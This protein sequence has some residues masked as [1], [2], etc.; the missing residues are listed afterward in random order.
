MTIQIESSDAVATRREDYMVSNKRLAFKFNKLESSKK[1]KTQAFCVAPWLHAHV[2][3]EGDRRLCCISDKAPEAYAKLPWQ[4]FKNS[5]YMK[6][7]RTQMLSNQVPT[8]CSACETPNRKHVYRDHLNNEYGSEIPE[9]LENTEADG[10]TSQK[11]RFLDYRSN[12]C[13]LKCRTC[14]PST[15]SANHSFLLKNFN[16]EKRWLFGDLERSTPK[17]IMEY[18]K[19]VYAVEALELASTESIDQIYFAGGEPLLEQGHL[20]LL[21]KLS[22]DKK[23]SHVSLAYN[24]N[25]SYSTRILEEWLPV[26][27]DF[28]RT[29]VFISLDGTGEVGEYIRNG[30]EMNLFNKNLDFLIQNKPQRMDLVLDLTLTS[31]NIFFLKDFAKYALSKGLK[32]QAKLMVNGAFSFPLLR[33]EIIPSAVKHLLLGQWD[34][35]FSDLSENDR[36]LLAGLNEAMEVFRAAPF[37]SFRGLDKALIRLKMFES[38]YP[39]TN[40]FLGLLK[41]DPLGSVWCEI[42]EQIEKA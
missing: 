9:I 10:S 14:T 7:I 4:D 16:A 5:E 41:K 22:E 34:E 38:I 2:D 3:A 37:D 19:A 17:S 21:K 30:L 29:Q 31:L 26:A 28:K 23:A 18:Y 11:I 40:S 32:T 33:C 42:L 27:S 24:T 12:L 8:E 35:Y 20:L 15:S 36:Q 13:N 1:E 6:R 25:L 39:D